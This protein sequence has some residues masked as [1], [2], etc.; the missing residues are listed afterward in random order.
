[1][2][3]KLN[4]RLEELG[5]S[6]FNFKNYPVNMWDIYGEKGIPLRV[7][8]SEMGPLMLVI[9]GAKRY[10]DWGFN[11]IFKV[12]DSDGL[13]LIDS[14]DLMQMINFLGENR[15]EI[16]KTYGNVASQSF[17]AISRKLLFIEDAGTDSMESLP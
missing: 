1:M 12:A 17:S 15:D 11:I 7:T 4:S 3:D 14:K 8:V 5:I 10:P 6:I 13:L 2:N 16:S 9:F